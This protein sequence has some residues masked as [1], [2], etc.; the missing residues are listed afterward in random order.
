MRNQTSKSVRPAEFYSAAMQPEEQ[1][2]ESPL[3]AQA[4]GLCSARAIK[5]YP[6][7]TSHRLKALWVLVSNLAPDN[8]FVISPV[9]KRVDFSVLIITKQDS[10]LDTFAEEKLG[11]FRK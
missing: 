9:N 7:T 2:G 8:V 10:P 6:I 4:T 11:C 3:G 1:R 5:P